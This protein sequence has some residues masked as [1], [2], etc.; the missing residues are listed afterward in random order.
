MVRVGLG[1]D[2]HRLVEGRPLLRGGVEV[3]FGKGEAA[4]SDGDVLLHALIDAL[5]G[6]AALGDIG[7]RYPDSDPCWKDADSRALLCRAWAEVRDA[8]WR[9]GNLDCVVMLE[10]PRVLPHREAIRASIAALL[11]VPTDRVF[12]KGKTG[13]GVGEVGRGEVVEAWVTCLLEK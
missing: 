11:E 6:A 8:G 10:V 13:E 7:E 2:R 5:L 1:W 3:P 12:L 4:H 9:L